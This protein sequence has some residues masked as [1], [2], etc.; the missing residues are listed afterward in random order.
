MLLDTSGH[1]IPAESHG[2][3]DALSLGTERLYAAP[4][5]K[6]RARAGRGKTETR[7]SSGAREKSW[8]PGE[9][10]NPRPVA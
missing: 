10:S 1:F 5:P 2:F 9:E 6:R 8:R 7:R 3:A 4:A